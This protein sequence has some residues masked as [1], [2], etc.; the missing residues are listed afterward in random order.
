MSFQPK[1]VKGKNVYR[2]D[3]QITNKNILFFWILYFSGFFFLSSLSLA[4]KNYFFFAYDQNLFCSEFWGKAFAV[5]LTWW[6]L[7][8][9]SVHFPPSLVGYSFYFFFLQKGYT[10]LP[11]VLPYVNYI[12]HACER[13]WF[14]FSDIW[15]A[16]QS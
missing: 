8:L 12:K 9:N 3:R 16:I 6:W 4:P 13:L 1:D 11:S 15:R 7:S 2:F 5:L 14:I 10:F